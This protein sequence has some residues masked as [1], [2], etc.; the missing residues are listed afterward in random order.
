MIVVHVCVFH[1]ESWRDRRHGAE[2]LF[3]GEGVGRRGREVVGGVVVDPLGML[4]C[5]LRVHQSSGDLLGV[6]V[7]LMGIFGG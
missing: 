6:D 3:R 5:V 1:G 7:V 4:G 2:L